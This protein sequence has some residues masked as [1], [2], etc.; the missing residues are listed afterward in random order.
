MPWPCFWVEENGEAEFILRRLQLSEEARAEGGHFHEAHAPIGFFPVRKTE[1]HA[2]AMVK[3]EEFEGHPAWPAQCS[4]CSFEFADDDIWQV[5]QE[6][7]FVRPETGETW[8]QRHLP[9]GAMYDA[10]WW[11]PFGVGPDG[12]ALH[13]IL[14]PE[15]PNMSHNWW[16]VDGGASNGPARNAWTRTGDPRARP[17]TV[18]VN[19]SIAAPGYHGYLRHGV[20]TDPV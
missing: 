1:D 5:H 13:V 19:P 11:R 7:V 3:P 9:I 17:P 20:L 16:H 12:I 6:A 2:F 10:K 15:K 14:P 4:K 8:T 18:D